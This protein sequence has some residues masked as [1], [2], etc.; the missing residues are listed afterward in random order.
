MVR[1][2]CSAP[3]AGM[4]RI[5]FVAVEGP[6]AVASGPRSPRAVRISSSHTT[7]LAQGPSSSRGP[8]LSPVRSGLPRVF[9]SP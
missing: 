6:L 4:T 9:P 2:K 5:R 7:W 3:F 1:H 8:P